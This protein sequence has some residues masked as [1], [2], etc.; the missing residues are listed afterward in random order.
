MGEVNNL[1]W[2]KTLRAFMEKIEPSLIATEDRKKCVVFLL[3]C[4]AR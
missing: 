4:R 1:L 3:G 2:G